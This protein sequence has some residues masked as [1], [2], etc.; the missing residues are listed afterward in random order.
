MEALEHLQQ[1]PLFKQLPPQYLAA[2]AGIAK[3]ERFV[4]GQR[5]VAQS[6]LGNRFFIVDSGLVNLRRTDIDGIERSI[7]VVSPHPLAN[8]PLESAKSYFGEQMFTTQEP[9]EFH[10][11]AVRPTEAL[12]FTRDDFDN[13]VKDKPGLVHMLGFV[14]AAERKRTHGFEWVAAGEAVQLVAHKHW[15]ALLPG[16]V[17]VT[18]LT[19]VAALVIFGLHFVLVT[20]ILQWIVL[21]A[22]ILIGL[23]LGWVVYDWLNDEYIVTTQRVAHVERVWL[24]IELRESVP[25][26]KVLGV[27]LERKFPSDYF[28]VSAVIIQTAGREQGDVTFAY[29]SN[30][31]AI[32]KLIQNQQSRVMARDAAEERERFRQNI[33]LELRHFLMPETV[34]AE[35]A[36]A[37]AAQ[38]P[39]T[40]P[41]PTSSWATI[42][43]WIRSWLDVELKEPGRTTWRKHWIVLLKQAGKWLVAL[44]VLDVIAAFFAL[45]R[46]QQFP[47]YWLGGLAALV[48]LLGLLLWE[49]EDWRNDIYAV[50]DNMVIDTESLP[51]GLR[52]KSTI[53]PLDQVQDIR[54]EVPGALAFFLN[55]GNVLI[56]TA[57]KSGQMIF[58]S[59]H[60]PR[61]AQDQIFRRLQV[62]R[63]RRTE[64]E[65]SLRSHA[66][67]DALLAYDRLKHEQQ[68]PPATAP[69]ETPPNPNPGA[70][71]SAPSQ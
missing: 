57:G 34:A 39:S 17:P 55:Y 52:S 43:S 3:R 58:Y 14:D 65:E 63:T 29:V 70:G 36:A 33:R 32:R 20:D 11:E 9:F 31:E 60:D 5:L 64:K 67:V 23:V 40:P 2:L 59:I 19:G 56:E 28:G 10:A 54:V 44:V 8:A 15:W 4:P 69:G 26:D 18:I 66:V 35:R 62:A 50:T 53:A 71:T 16:L 51:L 1:I 24:T 25:I 45:N 48:I 46:A 41:R 27:T 21:G 49:W 7:G 22:G 61:D 68:A 42:Q 12:V 6:D 30:G 38:A 13:L 37:E 47:G